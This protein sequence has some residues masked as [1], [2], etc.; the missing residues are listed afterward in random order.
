LLA[1]YGSDAR[2]TGVMPLELG[3]CRHRKYLRGVKPGRNKKNAAFLTG[4]KT[5]VVDREKLNMTVS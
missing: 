3:N 2:M 5:T 1:L 4:Y